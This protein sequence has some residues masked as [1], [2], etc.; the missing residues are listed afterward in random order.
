MAQRAAEEASVLRGEARRLETELAVARS[1]K[2]S[3]KKKTIFCVLK[4]FFQLFRDVSELRSALCERDKVILTLREELQKNKEAAVM[5]SYSDAHVRSVE[6]EN[7]RLTKQVQ[8]LREDLLQAIK[9]RHS[10]ILETLGA[11]KEENKVCDD[12]DDVEKGVLP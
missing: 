10:P 7:G 11:S 12:D 3:K 5:Q 9:L 2:A 6:N 8:Q 1:S 4:I